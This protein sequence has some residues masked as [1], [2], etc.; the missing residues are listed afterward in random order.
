M[1]R[2]FDRRPHREVENCNLAGWGREFE[3]EV[4]SLS[5]VIHVF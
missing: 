4:S 2:A 1:D 5:N 3:P